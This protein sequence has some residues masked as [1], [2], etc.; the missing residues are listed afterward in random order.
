MNALDWLM[1]V[2]MGILGSTGQAATNKA[3]R[4]MA[5]EQMEFQ[6][7]MSS[8]AVRR[9]VA[10]LEAAGLN[11]AL[12]YSGS[13]SSPGGASATMGDV[14]GAG[15]SNA[16]QTAV[17]AQEMRLARRQAE[18]MYQLTRQQA[19]KVDVETQGQRIANQ[20]LTWDGIL[21][22]QQFDFNKLVQPYMG[23]KAAADALLARLQVP[24]ARNQA[25]FEEWAGAARP[26]MSAAKTLSEIMRLF[27][28]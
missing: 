10:D 18:A 3:N 11:P 2:G 12:A 8:T 17:A 23:Q 15:L 20:N 13:A 21:K 27:R 28:R 25:T 16:R 7:R 22:G 14:T 1:S 9:H 26:G 5:R 19:A 24:G 6:E 4:A